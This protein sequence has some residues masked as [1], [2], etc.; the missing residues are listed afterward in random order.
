MARE[1]VDLLGNKF[2]VGKYKLCFNT[3]IKK[4]PLI[5]TRDIISGEL[6][7]LYQKN[8]QKYLGY[9]YNLSLN[10]Y[11]R[12]ELEL[13]GYQEAQDIRKSHLYVRKRR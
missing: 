4:G 12:Y 6:F 3:P 10:L 1:I 13:I 2:K 7:N 5:F 9:F 11:V 8:N